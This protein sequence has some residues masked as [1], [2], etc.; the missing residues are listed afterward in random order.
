MSGGGK[1]TTQTSQ[2]TIPPEVLARYNQ[3]N[4]RADKVDSQPFQQYGGQFVAPVNATQQGAI[5]NT[6]AAAG[7]AQPAFQQALGLAGSSNYSVNPQDL[8][9]QKY[10]SPYLDKVLGSESALLNQN[11]QQQQAGQLGTAIQSGAFG[12]DRAG[13]AAANLAQQQS[14]ANANIYSNILNQG[15]GQ[16]LS[17]AQ[18][19]Q[20]VTLGAEQANRA[21]TQNVAQL[22]AGLGAAGQTAAL[23][24]ADAQ[25]KAG[26]VEQ[27]TQQAQDSALYNQFLQ[28]QSLPYQ[29][30]AQ[31]AD[32]AE[33]IGSLSGSTTTTNTQQNGFFSDERLKDDAREIGRT[34]D[35]QP[36]YSYRYK[37]D[38][39]TQIG[40][41]AGE[42][43]HRH[44]DAV[45]LASG[46]KT[47]DY[48]KATDKA[49][50]RGHFAM[51]GVPFIG[52]GS[53]YIGDGSAADA[54]SSRFQAMYGSL[55]APHGQVVPQH[56][57]GNY[58]LHSAQP[59][60]PQ[61]P[62]A[63][64]TAN[65]YAQL[66]TNVNKAGSGLGLWGGSDGVDA[67]A[68]NAITPQS[69]E[70]DALASLS[71]V[72]TGLATG[73]SS[74]L[75]Y[76]ASGPQLDIPDTDKAYKL[77]PAQPQGGNA[78]Q[79]G[80]S[81]AMSA[82]KTIASIIPMLA[83][84]GRVG[85]ADG[86]AL[87]EDPFIMNLLNEIQQR[88]EGDDD[89]QDDASHGEK[90]VHSDGSGFMP[91][92]LGGKREV[93]Y[94]APDLSG[95]A[96]GGHLDSE[97]V[98]YLKEHGVPEHVALGVAAGIH[99][100]SGNR[101]GV[102]NP[103]SGAFGLG[104][105]LGSRAEGLHA[106][107]GENP[108]KGEQLEYLLSELKGGDR[109][110][111]A[112][113]SSRSPEEAL[114]NYITKFMRPAKGYETDRDIS[115]GLG[116]LR[117]GFADGGVPMGVQ[118]DDPQPAY[119]P[120]EE[121][122]KALAGFDAALG[123][124]NPA[125]RA[126]IDGP[127]PDSAQP[128]GLATR[129]QNM[130]TQEPDP[131]DVKENIRAISPT[132]PMNSAVNTP[133]R[134]NDPQAGAYAPDHR[135][136][137]KE[138]GHGKTDAV[139]SALSGLAAFGTANTGNPLTALAT[140]LGAGA[141]AYQGQRN[142]EMERAK[143][144][145]DLAL[146]QSQNV[147]NASMAS[148]S[149]AKLP[150]DISRTQAEAGLINA[151][152]NRTVQLTAPEVSKMVAEGQ[153]T[154]AEAKAA[155]AGRIKFL[156][157]NGGYLAVDPIANTSH[158]VKY[159]VSPI[160]PS[161]TGP[162][163][164]VDNSD[165]APS[166]AAPAVTPANSPAGAPAA[167][168]QKFRVSPNPL[169]PNID[170]SSFPKGNYYDPKY[171][172]EAKRNQGIALYGQLQDHAVQANQA[173]ANLTKIEQDATRS[174]GFL[175]PGY[176]GRSRLQAA[177]AVNAAARVLGSQNDIYDT[178][179]GEES[180]KLNNRAA[181]DLAHGIGGHPGAMIMQ[182]MQQSTPGIE[183]SK[184]GIVFIAEGIKQDMQRQQALAAFARKYMEQ[185]PT[186]NLYGFEEAFNKQY[187]PA[188]WAARAREG[189]ARL[190]AD[191]EDVTY[192]LKNRRDPK[193]VQEFRT[194]YDK[195]HGE[196]VTDMI[197]GGR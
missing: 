181:G 74:D 157:V 55:L 77:Q 159:S 111:P 132:T 137:F 160:P 123:A 101:S 38:H 69:A 96:K 13:I 179:G 128:S 172:G 125:P 141:Q 27:Q 56:A 81:D 79:S 68:L 84:G 164:T 151:N 122:R 114:Q 140:G 183:N 138:L 193:A 121:K 24:G 19:Q 173:I 53:P 10:L 40:L 51:G 163:N 185:N 152:A 29:Q 184:N 14:L 3:I 61:Q 4:A 112:V 86:G 155:E 80:F 67:S 97:A 154:Q 8:N 194:K 190:L 170:P 169:E 94:S 118:P 25:L 44:P 102:R 153:L 22:T 110:G 109:G 98:S 71:D 167:Q 85:R 139:L 18:Q 87:S 166:P 9:V 186:R 64:Q 197:L 70:S 41:M 158:F 180:I 143:T 59:S 65:D 37:G 49:A 48:K 174:K 90:N 191:R 156:A 196:G 171:G 66:A 142:F 91:D 26:S 50:E 17:T 12:G 43:E 39:R 2:V 20:G 161:T 188:Y 146:R 127:A 21:N 129:A 150:Y 60:I 148:Q 30:L 134:Y 120:E 135:N 11:N 62:S 100:E 147:T 57:G 126:V 144:A 133:D 88:Y 31:Q 103:K 168:P 46:Y 175:T 28:Q 177:M 131:Q 1:G 82:V 5:A 108:T 83:K 189:A 106:K 105:W 162:G 117:A 32:I 115:S 178:S 130:A 58:Q 119:D 182:T 7:Q 92:Y 195:I 149:A 76:A 192:L 104:Q 34:F 93:G 33:G 107:Y 95:V 75:P 73:G 42:V 36:I 78:G 187:P 72:R 47:V 99:A 16:A 165:G 89:S 15:Y 63:A 113:L 35:G 45:G 136:F 52:D 6:T 116:A 54:M 145:Q 124:A 23:Q 176:A